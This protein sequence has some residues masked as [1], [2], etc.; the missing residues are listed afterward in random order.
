M[1]KEIIK[2]EIIRTLESILEQT[3]TIDGYEG[4]IPQIELDIIQDNIR[5]L[6]QNF[7]YLDKINQGESSSPQMEPQ[8][9][10]TAEGKVG[11]PENQEE[12][13]ASEKDKEEVNRQ[14]NDH[15]NT[16]TGPQSE[17]KEDGKQE[18]KEKQEEHE[19]VEREEEDESAQ[20][21][22]QKQKLQEKEE[23]K[24]TEIE[25]KEVEE[26]EPEAK[27]EE[28]KEYEQQPVLEQKPESAELETETEVSEEESRPEEQ[29]E[30]EIENSSD[31]NAEAKEEIVPEKPSKMSRAERREEKKKQTAQRKEAKK[32][33]SGATS[34]AEDLFSQKKPEPKSSTL[35]E[36]LQGSGASSLYDRI[37]ASKASGSLSDRLK[38]K[39][40]KDI[41]TAI[42]IN[43]KFLFI[44]ELFKGNMHDYNDA[45]KRLNRAGDLEKAIAV[46]DEMKEKYGWDSEG[47]STLQLLDFVERRYM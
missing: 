4:Q 38:K 35:A 22:E 9:L 3:E 27:Q 17:E 29:P 23:E 19:S 11:E 34:A 8:E 1:S 46:F 33:Q 5:H 15:L 43:E 45:I 44:N 10:D 41:K 2:E 20:A 31:E 13:K 6:Y 40:V 47:Q 42:G 18:A 24:N 26:A 21:V 37:G 32:Q 16:E 39:P 36:K 28:E 12:T 14:A 30:N 25:E 7:I